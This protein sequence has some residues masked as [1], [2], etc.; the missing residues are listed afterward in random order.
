[1]YI[2]PTL[3]YLVMSRGGYLEICTANY[4]ERYGHRACFLGWVS[5][6]S[7]RPVKAYPNFRLGPAAAAVDD[8]DLRRSIHI[9]YR[10]MFDVN[11]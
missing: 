4:C 3:L 6:C 1:M 2:P 10:D 8:L 9:S 11:Q 5:E 7:V